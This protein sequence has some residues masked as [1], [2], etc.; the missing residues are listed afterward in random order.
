MAMD[1]SWLP[2]G[3]DPR[4]LPAG[5]RNHNPG[6]IKYFKGLNYPGM[7]GPSANTDQ[8][9]P[10][11]TF[12]TPQSGM[13]AM[14]SL[15]L[16]KYQGGKRSPMDLIAGDRGWTP[17]N[18]SAAA[19]VARTM[20]IDPNADMNLSD[21]QQLS[22]FLRALAQQEHGSASKLYGDDIYATAASGAKGNMN[23]SSAMAK[24]LRQRYANAP[25]GT[26]APTTGA[27]PVAA[28]GGLERLKAALA[29]KYDADKL[30][31]AEGL[32]ASGQKTAGT[33]GNWIGALGG[34]LLAGYGGYARDQELSGKKAADE[35]MRSG[36]TQ[37]GDTKEMARLL[38]ASA[39]PEERAIGIELFA[40]AESA[41][42]ANPET[43]GTTPQYFEDP[44]TKELKFGVLSNKGNFKAMNAPGKVLPPT[45]AVD[46]ATGTQV[47]SRA[48]GVPLSTVPKDIVGKER[49]EE[50][51]KGQGSAQV[52]LPRVESNTDS[53]L[54]Q[55]DATRT[56]PYLPSMTGPINAR[57]PNLSGDAARV[58]SKVDQL[59]GQAFLQAFQSLKGAGQI[60][61]IEGTKATAALSRLQTM[62]VND[63]DY[64]TS[65]DDFK[66]EV[67]RLRDLARQR[68]GGGA[69]APATDAAQPPA[70]PPAGSYKVLKV[71]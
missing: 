50:V 34:T 48:G 64:A 29:G 43:F 71:H 56:D 7:L 23:A 60:T 9:D 52:D 54:S 2:P 62:T 15:A 25:I 47:T 37:S 67:I 31:G 5:M 61:E 4:A 49:M 12:D 69:P 3:V 57:M 24:S 18:T 55:L 1:F 59:G 21:P 65:L 13:N 26:A 46:T 17:G 32:I 51:G 11:M 14:A 33:S 28:P 16:R 39:N 35:Q 63:A 44:A 45:Y 70:A 42:K 8:G 58:Q 40:K 6:N 30:K 66:G 22:T 20:G 53:M 41:L 27:V 10:Q 19:N 68:A 38:M 36:L